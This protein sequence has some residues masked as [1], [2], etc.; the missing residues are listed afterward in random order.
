MAYFT[1]D[2][3]DFFKELAANNHKDWFDENRKRYHTSV[4][5]PFDVF[6][7]DLISEVKQRDK[8][9]D[10]APKDAIF[11]INR[12]IRFSND[13]TPYKLNRSAIISP[14]GRKDK[15]FPGLYIEIGP[16]FCRVYGGVYMPDKEQLYDIRET[17]NKDPKKLQKLISDKSFTSVFGELRGEKNKVIP[18]EFKEVGAEFDTIYNKQ[19]YWFTEMKPEQALKDDFMKNV[20]KAYEANKAVMDYFKNAMK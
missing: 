1:K 6:V 3:F 13:K 20:V 11:R 18:K 9:V 19:F 12:D 15:S 17:I 4:K 16:E 2:Y 8:A 7:G 5:E 14:K 10:I